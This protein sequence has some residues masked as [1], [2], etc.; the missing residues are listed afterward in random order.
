M[1]LR[2][3]CPNQLSISPH[4][5]CFQYLILAAVPL[6]RP[7]MRVP[8]LRLQEDVNLY[9]RKGGFTSWV[10]LS[11]TGLL[12]SSSAH[13]RNVISITDRWEYISSEGDR[14]ELL[15]R[16]KEQESEF[17]ERWVRCMWK[18]GLGRDR[19]DD[20]WGMKEG[21]GVKLG[22]GKEMGMA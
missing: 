3:E 6:P 12:A 7:A 13:F 10:H 17:L 21:H 2:S 14:A 22:G 19:S 15:P 1:L 16:K 4:Q 20:K 9:S 11:P 5:A 18:G 8:T